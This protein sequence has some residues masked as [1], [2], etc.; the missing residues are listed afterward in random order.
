MQDKNTLIDHGSLVIIIILSISLIALGIAYNS[1]RN[2]N[3]DFGQEM[4]HIESDMYDWHEDMDA[5][6]KRLDA[7]E[8]VLLNPKIKIMRDK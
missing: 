2:E 6:E 5:L 8:I 1:L 4:N 7:I 3:C